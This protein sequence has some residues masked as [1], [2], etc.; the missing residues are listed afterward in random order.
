MAYECCDTDILNSDTDELSKRIDN[1]SQMRSLP[2]E[3]NLYPNNFM[4]DGSQTKSSTIDALD[5]RIDMVWKRP[6]TQ[7]NSQNRP[8]LK[9]MKIKTEHATSTN[10]ETASLSEA[11]ATPKRTHMNVHEMIHDVKGREQTC[12]EEKFFSPS[13]LPI[14]AND[15]PTEISKPRLE[16]QDAFY[17]LQMPQPNYYDVLYAPIGELEDTK[18]DSS[19]LLGDGFERQAVYPKSQ[20]QQSSLFQDDKTETKDRIVPQKFSQLVHIPY[21][22]SPYNCMQWGDS[23]L[24][25]TGL[26]TAQE[27]VLDQGYRMPLLKQLG[28]DDRSHSADLYRQQSERPLSNKHI[29]VRRPAR[30]ACPGEK[31]PTYSAIEVGA[32]E[33]VFIEAQAQTDFDMETCVSFVEPKTLNGVSCVPLQCEAFT[34]GHKKRIVT[35]HDTPFKVAAVN[36]P[37]NSLNKEQ[38]QNVMNDFK[39]ETQRL[40]T[41]QME[42]LGKKLM[43]KLTTKTEKNPKKKNR[44]V[45]CKLCD[46][47]EHSIFDCKSRHPNSKKHGSKACFRC[48]EDNHGVMDCPKGSPEPKGSGN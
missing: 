10:I 44:R 4:N 39:A 40:V 28:N 38:I 32:D 19:V 20:R 1:L 9:P 29:N 25:D 45:Y 17:Q 5:L 31:L 6:G 35:E 46:C 30:K 7:M 2:I 43:Q 13:A 16:R 48:G 37:A 33:R 41:S 42:K 8:L 11:G 22:S 15:C 12:E 34:R 36:E 24:D 21:V 18:Y 3:G 26:M 14:G 47:R 23:D 27:Y